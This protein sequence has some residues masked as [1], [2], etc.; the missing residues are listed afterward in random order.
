MFLLRVRQTHTRVSDYYAHKNHYTTSQ[1][2]YKKLLRV[3]HMFPIKL[4]VITM[5]T[6]RRTTFTV[7]LVIP[8]CYAFITLLRVITVLTTTGIK[9][10][11]LY[12]KILLHN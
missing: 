6:I 5:L 1:C 4:G 8:S 12:T 9:S 11:G 10:R 2:I 7:I 3:H